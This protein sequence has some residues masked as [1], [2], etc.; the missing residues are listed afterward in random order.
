MN[1]FE[2]E[3]DIRVAETLSSDFYTDDGYFEESK[4]RIFARTWQVVGL[5]SEVNNLMPHMLL[6]GFL[7]E[8]I[9]ITRDTDENLH[10]FSNTCTHRGNILVQNECR[11][12]GIRCGY[13]GRRFSL[14]GKFLSM[15]E[16]EAA[17]N[18]PS[19]RDDLRSVSFKTWKDFVFA[20]LD[21]RDPFEEFIVETGSR[22]AEY[23]FE[24]HE[25]VERKHYLVKAHWALYCENF[26]EGFHIPYVHKSLNEVLDYGRYSTEL[27]RYSSLQTGYDDDGDTSA[28]YF[29]VFPNLMYNFYPWGLSVNIVKPIKSNLTKVEYMTFVLDRSKLDQ[30]AGA[31]LEKVELEDQAVAESVQ[32]GINSRFYKRGRY[33][34]TREKGVHHFHRLISEFMDESNEQSRNVRHKKP[35]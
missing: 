1:N 8:P 16:F 34:P 35:N 9:L 3:P 25:L 21:P 28:Q 33:S 15:P 11:R 23:D 30:G 20:S 17:K 6:E 5:E 13:H 14:D 27:F 2:I 4:R 19:E 29:F 7:D 22:T 31:N 32:R 12:D 26:L 18:F 24:R 10:C